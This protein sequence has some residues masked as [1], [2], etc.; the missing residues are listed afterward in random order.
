MDHVQLFYYPKAKKLR[1]QLLPVT[2]KEELGL[3]SPGRRAEQTQKAVRSPQATTLAH[4]LPSILQRD[5]GQPNARV[6]LLRLPSPG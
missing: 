2:L 1:L 5:F 4:E 3:A 6:T